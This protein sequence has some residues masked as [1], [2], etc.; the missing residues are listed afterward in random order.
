MA[1]LRFALFAL[2]SIPASI[3]DIR[4]RKIPNLLV[5]AGLLAAFGSAVP[6]PSRIVSTLLGGVAGLVLF[7]GVW[8]LAKGGLGMGD[9][10]YASYIGAS[11]GIAMLPVALFVSAAFAL[12]S[13]LVLLAARRATMRSRLPF[14]PFLSAGGLAALA[15]QVLHWRLLTPGGVG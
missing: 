13:A 7:L 4:T 6:P 12:F 11:T 2:I 10:K 3:I 1:V 9:V 14:A 15:A 5:I 8:Y